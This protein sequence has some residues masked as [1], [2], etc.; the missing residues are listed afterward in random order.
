LFTSNAQ[1]KYQ[2]DMASYD[3]SGRLNEE[4]FAVKPE[5]GWEDPL[6]L[7]FHAHQAFI[8]GGL[9]DL[10]SCPPSQPR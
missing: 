5:A 10:K 6:Y 2:L 9:R 1:N 4:S 3:R 8:G 7:Y